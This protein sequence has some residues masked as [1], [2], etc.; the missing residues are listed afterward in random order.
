MFFYC[1]FMSR[2]VSFIHYLCQYLCHVFTIYV[3]MRVIHSLFLSIIMSFIHY[4]RQDVLFI[5][6]LCQD[7]CHLFTIYGKHYVIYPLRTLRFVIYSVDVKIHAHLNMSMSMFML[8]IPIL[9]EDLCHFFLVFVHINVILL[10]FTSKFTSFIHYLCQ[11][12]VIY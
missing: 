8:F 12:S 6:Y 5:H 2:F 10:L 7:L 9:C 1:L 4:S 11:V 3:K